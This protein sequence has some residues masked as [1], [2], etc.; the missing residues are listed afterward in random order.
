MSLVDSHCHL[1]DTQF[2]EDRQQTL[3]RAQEAGVQQMLAIGT[4]EGPPDLEAAIRLAEKHDILLATVGVHPQFAAAVEE[5][6]LAR[7]PALLK[8]RKVMAVGEIGL[9][10]HYEPIPKKE[11]F[12]LFIQQMQMAHDARKPIII[13]TRDAWDD[14]FALLKQH[15]SHTGLPCILHCFTGSPVQARQALD[16]DCYLSFAGILTYPKAVDVHESAKMVPLHRLLVETDSPYL[17]PVPFRGKR[18]EPAHVVHTARR[19]AE[20]RGQDFELIAAVTTSNFLKLCL[21]A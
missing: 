10:Y 15:W 11:Q 20:L 1:D 9:D 7:I 6:T 14:T 4:G 8:H 19:L 3:D 5:E 21:P 2:D 13:H 16:L 17:A 12:E 18:N